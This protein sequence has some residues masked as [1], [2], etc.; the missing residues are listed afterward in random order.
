MLLQG[1]MEL[2]FLERSK[3]R[4]CDPL[5]TKI[6]GNLLPT[7]HNGTDCEKYSTIIV[8]NRIVCGR[9]I[10]LSCEVVSQMG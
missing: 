4:P 8:G 5:S 7:G 2:S 6:R 10:R 3:Q 9:K 1:V